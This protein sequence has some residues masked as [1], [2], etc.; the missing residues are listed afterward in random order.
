[1]T[2]KYTSMKIWPVPEPGYSQQS[3]PFRRK[4]ILTRFGL[5]ME[6]LRLNFMMVISNLL[7][8]LMT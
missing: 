1:M 5:T 4:D 3:E 8:T 6:T 7:Q 2:V